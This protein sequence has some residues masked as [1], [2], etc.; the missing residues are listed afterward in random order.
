[1]TNK[2]DGGP[3]FPHNHFDLADDEH[4]LSIRDY[5]AA[6]A[7]QALAVYEEYPPERAAEYAYKYADAMLKAREA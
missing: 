4:G 1:M 5:F 6:K 2:H 3:A 7:M